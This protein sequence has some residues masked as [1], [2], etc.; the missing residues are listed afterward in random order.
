LTLP[1]GGLAYFKH[2]THK[3]SF[4]IFHFHNMS[5]KV[6]KT[7]VITLNSDF[8]VL[9]SKFHWYFTKFL[10]T[11]CRIQTFLHIHITISGKLSVLPVDCNI[12]FSDFD[13]AISL[14]L[15]I[16]NTTVMVNS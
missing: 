8:R 12:V 9:S 7:R 14:L 15:L 13:K 16:Q 5:F 2:N 3:T 6:G 4:L 10:V 11:T 1:F